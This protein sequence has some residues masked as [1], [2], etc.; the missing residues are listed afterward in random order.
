MCVKFSCLWYPPLIPAFSAL[1]CKLVK[2]FEM[3][4]TNTKLDE[5]GMFDYI[6]LVK[7]LSD[8]DIIAL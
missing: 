6:H 1:S 2:I 4:S 8:R 5:L 3:A 7:D